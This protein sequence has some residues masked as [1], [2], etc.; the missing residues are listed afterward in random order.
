[1]GEFDLIERIRRRI[2]ASE[3]VPVGIGD[4]A[5]VIMPTPGRALVATTDALVLDRHFTAAWKP[6][7]IGH[8]AMHANLSDLAA[9]G[10]RPRW[11][12][13][14]LTLPQCD[15]DWLDGFLD[16]FLGAAES[17]DV[18]LVGGNISSGPL[19]IAVELLGE[20]APD[21]VATRRGAC[22]GDRLIVTG[23]LG[24]AAAALALG[25][26]AP[27]ALLARLHRPQARVRAGD[28][29]AGPAHALIDISDGLLADLGHL[30]GGQ[31]GAEIHL[32]R[33]PTSG[34]LTAAVGDKHVRWPLQAGGGNDYELLAAV[35]AH[36][37]QSLDQLAEAA[38]TTLTDI[39]RIDDS[40]KVR[41]LDDRGR[42]LADLV[43][44][45][46]HFAS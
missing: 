30:L 17:A 26:D 36:P 16:G 34:A 23:T 45:W 21:R 33:L 32:D 44:G 37:E 11:A 28:V 8:L 24:D 1:M 41:C 3:S 14:A 4:D 10:A 7:D 5:A 25:D 2:R 29:L 40:G 18:A 46:D 6:S 9:M 35:P 38:G 39:G 42:E 31:L 19:N 20:V 22:P 43:P 13:L 27:E 15:P 12:L